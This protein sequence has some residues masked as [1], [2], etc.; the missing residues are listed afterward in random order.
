MAEEKAKREKRRQMAEER[1]KQ[2]T[3]S[4]EV[5]DQGNFQLEI[6]KPQLLEL[7]V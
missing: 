4:G 2:K 7:S 3:A 5:Q 1:K 6:L